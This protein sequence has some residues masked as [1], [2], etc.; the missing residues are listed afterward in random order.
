MA[1]LLVLLQVNAEAQ[2]VHRISSM[3]ENSLKTFIEDPTKWAP[4]DIIMLEGNYMETGHIS[5]T[6]D[7]TIIGDSE[8]AT[9]PMITFHGG[10]FRPAAADLSITLKGFDINGKTRDAEDKEVRAMI[11]EYGRLN[12]FGAKL[13]HIED[14]HAYGLKN[15]I[16]LFY[17]QGQVYDKIVVENV[18]WNDITDWVFNPR[19]NALKD[20]SITN[21]TFY[22]AGGFMFNPYFSKE[23]REEVIQQ[24][25]VV[26][27]NTFY[28]IGSENKAL[29]QIN[30]PKDASVSLT[31]SNN[32]VSTLK[33]HKNARPFLL[34]A[35]SGTFNFTNNVL[36]DFVATGAGG[37]AYNLDPI[38]ELS[39]VTVTDLNTNDPG[40]ANRAVGNFGLF[41]GSPLL[42]ADTEAGALGDPTW[43]TEAAIYSIHRISNAEENSLKTFIEDISKWSPDDIIELESAG[44]YI[45]RGGIEI[46]QD[47]T[48]RGAAGLAQRPLIVMHG[49]ALVP[50]AN[51][52]D[53]VLENFDMNGLTTNDTGSEQRAAIVQFGA[54]NKFENS[55]IL[56]EDM[57]ATGFLTGVELYYNSGLHYKFLTINR[58]NWSDISGWVIDPRINATDRIEVTNSTFWN[59]G[60]FLKN[61]YNVDPNKERTAVYPMVILIDHNTFY[62]VA[63][64]GVSGADVFL[65]LNDPK[66]GKIDFTFS[67]NI[68]STLGEQTT[69]RPFRINPTAGTFRFN[70]NLFHSFNSTREGGIYNLDAVAAAQSNVSVTNPVPGNPTFANPQE[71]NFT[72]PTDLGYLTAGTNGTIMGDPRWDPGLVTSS[73]PE[74]AA[75]KVEVYPNPVRDVLH[76]NS[77]SLVEVTIYNISGSA[78]MTGKIDR[79]GS[80][81]I[82]GLKSGLYIARINSGIKVQT[83]KLIKE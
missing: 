73:E 21:S 20:L 83:V 51:D 79:V 76:I 2:E 11:I 56:I 68:V 82:S 8:A 39:T 70:N 43:A 80:I 60:G 35:E 69:S 65:Q 7:I 48:I 59:I 24:K 19:I 27:H 31:F 38:S 32:I 41:T 61:P 67:N 45:V 63:S 23:G 40:F 47:I 5:I 1:V 53:I 37:L 54:D 26:D 25:I 52:L 72:L 58:V 33:D 3:E 66:E 15:G 12:A 75:A 71:G 4:G 29:F 55:T 44:E 13:I 78:V 22:N 36:H 42:K 49:G 64:T 81:N 34:S 9:R 46:K 62:N 17:N 30:D 57:N 50:K 28:R 6:Q 10:G 14:M 18:I 77:P 16:E 74:L